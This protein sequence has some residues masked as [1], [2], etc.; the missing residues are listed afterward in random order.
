MKSGLRI[1]GHPAH[2]AATHIPMGSLLLVPL[3]DLGAWLGDAPVLWTVA[4]WSLLAGVASGAVAATLGFLDYVALPA[5]RRLLTLAN[6]HALLVGTA[7]VL[8]LGSLLLRDGA[9]PPDLLSGG[10]S[11]AAAL[12]LVIG[13]WHG[14]ELVYGHGVGSEHRRL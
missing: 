10:L 1:L 9:S 2:A 3:W 11:A 8:A 6:R 12:L 14:A 7:I 5:E 4:R 13:G